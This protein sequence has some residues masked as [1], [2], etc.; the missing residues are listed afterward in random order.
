MH[1]LWHNVRS[2]C[3]D[4]GVNTARHAM[5]VVTRVTRYSSVCIVAGFED[6]FEASNQ[7]V[8]TVAVIWVCKRESGFV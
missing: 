2:P 4:N 3:F 5:S 7:Q 8:L 1:W 6:T